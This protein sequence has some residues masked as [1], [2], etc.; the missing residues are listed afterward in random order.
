MESMDSLKELITSKTFIEAC[1]HHDV[2]HEQTKL[3][4]KLGIE[5]ETFHG[6]R[7]S[8]AHHSLILSKMDYETKIKNG[9]MPMKYIQ[10]ILHQY[11]ATDE[12]RAKNYP[13]WIVPVLPPNRTLKPKHYGL[14]AACVC[15][16]HGPQ[17][18]AVCPTKID[19][20]IIDNDYILSKSN[21]VGIIVT[22]KD[23]PCI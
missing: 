10:Y 8:Y 5:C 11:A 15:Y 20:E 7:H 23:G 19:I 2:Q 16:A 3:V 18:F 6:A 12:G 22:F 1:L 4:K 9:Q 14:L 17:R 21:E 13:F